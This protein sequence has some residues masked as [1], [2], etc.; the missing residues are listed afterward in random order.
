MREGEYVRVLRNNELVQRYLELSIKWN[1]VARKARV[2]PSSSGNKYTYSISPMRRTN[3]FSNLDYRIR[4]KTSGAYTYKTK[5]S[6][7]E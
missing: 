6:S 4:M 2:K 7:Y 1:L 3:S 5:P